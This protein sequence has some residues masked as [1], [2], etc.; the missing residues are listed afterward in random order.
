[1]HAEVRVS[2][3]DIG[4]VKKDQTVRLKVSTFDFMR[5]GTIDGRVSMVS[6]YSVLDENQ[7]PYFKVNITVPKEY[8]GEDRTKKVEPGMTVQAD[9][10]TD[11][12]SVM[13]YL[14]RPIYVALN[15]GMR[16]R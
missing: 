8:V 16:E 3:V 13:R 7:N 14:L 15:Q 10:L 5:Y 1:M 6:P 12:Q 11:R 4:F 9:I 2:P